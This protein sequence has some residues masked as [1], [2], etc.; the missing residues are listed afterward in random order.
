MNL[1]NERIKKLWEKGLR[2]PLKISRKLGLVDQQRVIEGLN[3]LA[4][5]GD[6]NGWQ[7]KMESK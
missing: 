1:K 4:Q 6:I 5:Q 3:T 2:D 7:I